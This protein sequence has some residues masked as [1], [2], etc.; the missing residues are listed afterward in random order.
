[1]LRRVADQF[2]DGSH[3]T[4]DRHSRRRGRMPLTLILAVVVLS[5][6]LVAALR[7]PSRDPERIRPPIA[8]TASGRFDYAGLIHVHSSYSDD[9]SGTYASLARTAAA[10]GIRF[11]VVTD[12]NTLEP[13]TAGEEGWRDG[14]LMLTGVESSRPEGHL[15]GMNVTT[16]PM[17]REEPTDAFLTAMTNQNGLTL[18]A[19]AAHRKWAWEGPVDD[20]VDG[21]EILDLADQ[22]YAAPVAA[23]LTAIA[24]LPFN[25]M[26]AY[27]ELGADNAPTLRIWDRM[28]QQRRFVGVYAPDLHQ[29]IELWRGQSLVFPPAAEIMRI[30]RNHIVSSV[31]LS[32]DFQTDRALVYRAIRDGHLYVSLDVLGEAT[33]FMFTA[34]QDQSEAWMGDEITAG[35]QT[36]YSV[37]LPSVAGSM[38]AVTRVLRNGVEVTR[39]QPGALS[40]VYEDERPG[41]YRTETVVMIPTAFGPDR[42]AIWI[43]SN[44]IY[45]R[46]AT[47]G[48]PG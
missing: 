3:R 36:V 9:A 17:D 22:F 46:S 35:P 24:L 43:Y 6:P 28:T 39:S 19:H 2:A 34:R 15:L 4:A 47:A 37:S 23:K 29:S 13:I 38:G 25:R 7:V 5:V 32:G 18:L 40:F 31:P 10:Q 48:A 30:A 12:H 44:P 16:A 26:G 1:M 21:M 45:S 27:L 20:R 11:L 33:G 42:E 14:V 8:E 41:V